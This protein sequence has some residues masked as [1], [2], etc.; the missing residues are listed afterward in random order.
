MKNLLGLQFWH[1]FKYAELTEVIRQSD[2]LFLDLLTK[3]RVGN[4]DDDI[5]KLLKVIFTDK[6]DEKYPKHVLHLW[7]ENETSMKKE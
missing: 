6:S 5:E 4:I 2:K 7:A 1:L 3:V